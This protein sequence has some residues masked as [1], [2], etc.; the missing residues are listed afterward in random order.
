MVVEHLEA[1]VDEKHR[2]TIPREIRKQLGI[3]HRS[4]VEVVLRG[5][6]IIVKPVLPVKNPT[7]AI[8]GLVRKAEERN[9]KKR[10]REAVAKR[11]KAGNLS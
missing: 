11:K 3:G 2:V 10:S 8:W 7:Q 9:P 5:A 4:K 6:E 1:T